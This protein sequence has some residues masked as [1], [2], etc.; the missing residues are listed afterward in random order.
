[1]CFFVGHVGLVVAPADSFLDVEVLPLLCLQLCVV[2]IF[3]LV[4]ADTLLVGKH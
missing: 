1:M 4:E 3:G 2:V